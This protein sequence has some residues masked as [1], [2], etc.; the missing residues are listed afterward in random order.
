[1]KYQQ[2]QQYLRQ[3][4]SSKALPAG[5][6]IPSIRQL[7][8][9]FSYSKSTVIKALHKLEQEH[10]IYSV[11]QKGYFVTE[12]SIPQDN[13][14]KQ[15]DFLSA[16]PDTSYF[17]FENLTHCSNQI[18]INRQK[19]ILSYGQPIGMERLRKQILNYFQNQQIFTSINRLII[20]SGAQQAVN[21]LMNMPFPNGRENI[22]VEQPTYPGI[23]QAAHLTNHNIF[24]IDLSDNQ[25]DLEQLEYLFKNHEI[26]FFYLMSRFQNPLGHSYTATEKQKIIT[27]AEKYDV[28]LVEDDYLGDL[29]LDKKN[30]PLF[31]EDPSGRVI[32][33][34]SFSKVFL[35]SLRLAAVVIPSEM[36]PTFLK[37]KSYFDSYTSTISQEIL[38]TYMENGMFEQHLK[39][40]KQRYAQ[41]MSELIRCGQLYLP[42]NQQLNTPTTGFYTVL[43]LPKGVNS[44]ILTHKLMQQNVLVDDVARMFLPYQQKSSFIRLSISQVDLEQIEPGIK[45]IGSTISEYKVNLNPIFQGFHL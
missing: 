8:Q 36:I 2:L 23:L 38:A 10:I 39:N 21:I 42:Q 41:K 6:K 29:D 16:G 44:T 12:N 3:E 35:P 4:I 9:Q 15:I 37:Y 30:D 14:P 34:K 22:L 17:S 27:L 45:Q 26:K 19:E 32:Y 24:G 40:I 18:L 31:S 11:P 20:T 5:T 13:L 28:Y 1:M 7:S 43:K 25:I 33:L